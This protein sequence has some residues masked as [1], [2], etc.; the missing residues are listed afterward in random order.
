M[1]EL[2]NEPPG[3]RGLPP[4]DPN[5]YRKRVLAAV[6]R[7]GGPDTSDPFELYDLPLDLEI[8]GGLDDATVAARVAEVWAFWQ[9]QRDHP[10]YRALVALLVETHSERSAELLDGDGRRAAAARTRIRREERETARYALLDAAISRLVQRHGGVPPD[11]VEGLEEVGALGGLTPDEVATRVRR[12]RLLGPSIGPE[13]R[14]QIRA[15]LDEFGRLTGAAPP[16]TLL[17]LL[18]LLPDATDQQVGAGLTAWRSRARELPAGRLRAVVDELLVHVGELL[19]PGRAAVEAY[20]DAVAVEVGDYLRPRVRAAVLVEDRLVA[21]DH[22]HLLAEAAARGLDDRRA[23]EVIA[24]LAAELG[25]VVEDVPAGPD[26]GRRGDGGR[27]PDG[28]GSGD[29]PGVRGAVRHPDRDAGSGRGGGATS[30][31]PDAS[32]QELLRRARA[33]LRGGRPRAAQELVSAAADAGAVAAQA[34]ALADEIAALLADAE[35]RLKEAAA[36]EADRRWVTAA[37]ELDDL[38]RTA[39]DVVPDLD[40]R[41]ARARQEVVRATERY[42]AALAGPEAERGAALRALLAECRDHEGAKAALE[43]LAAT[44][45]DPP[46]WVNAARDLRGDVVVLWSPSTSHGVTYRVRRMRPDGTWQV[47][48]RV[49]DNSIED[50]GAPPGVEA[51]VYAVAAIHAGRRSTETRSDAAPVL[52]PAVPA[53]VLAVRAG[54]GTVDVTWTPVAGDV[55]YRVR[56]LDDD[57]WQ[58]VGRTRA[59]RLQ[60]GGAPAG[61]TPVYAVSA[62]RGGVRSAEG[63]SDGG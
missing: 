58:V 26:V 24:G 27:D 41:R 46:A 30:P 29:A 22:A 33:A 5:G 42:A 32:S 28:Q 48:G 23:A 4:F 49:T 25:A 37:F 43:R 2:T 63:R 60:D 3:P 55:E 16:P 61:T 35:G 45:P 57:R 18:G 54:D 12:H 20:L 13:R 10:R 11:K 56:R 52:G 21:D 47:V 53:G 59:T 7:R 40:E 44:P 51:P 6:E 62:A 31:V 38:A 15:L 14:R 1:S 17:V 19:A 50:G 36:A 39:S 8:A 9:R 34:R